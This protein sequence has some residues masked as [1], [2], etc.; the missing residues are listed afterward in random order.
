[1]EP[2]VTARSASLA[3]ATQ[4]VI[5]S[6]VTYPLDV[7]CWSD[8]LHRIIDAAD[9]STTPNAAGDVIVATG[10]LH[11]R[12]GTKWTYSK[13]FVVNIHQSYAY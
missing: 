6:H 4:E 5:D 3:P 2:L 10:G 12:V 8:I 1:M 9:R 13:S 7:L 11:I